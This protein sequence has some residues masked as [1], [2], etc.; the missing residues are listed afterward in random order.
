MLLAFSSASHTS[1]R[2]R[3]RAGHSRSRHRPERK[4]DQHLYNGY[5]GWPSQV[6]IADG[7]TTTYSYSNN[8]VVQPATTG[9]RWSRTTLDGFGRVTKVETGHDST[10]VSVAETNYA[11][12]ACSPLGKVWRVSRP[13]APGTNPVC[14]T[15]T[16][17]GSG[18]TLTVTTAA[19]EGT[20]T[21]TYRYQGNQT[22]VTDAAGKWKTFTNDAFGNVVSVAEP[23]PGTGGTQNPTNLAR[24]K[25]AS[26]GSTFPWSPSPTADKAVDG[27]TDGNFLDY[28]VTHTN[29]DVNAWWQVD[30]GAS[31]S[32]SSVVIWN[33]TDCCQDRLSDYWVFISDTP[34]S[35]SDTPATLQSRPGTWS[36]H[37]TSYPNPSTTIAAS[38]QGR[39]VRVQLS[40]TERL[41]MAEVQVM[42]AFG[43]SGG[44]TLTTN[45]I[46]NGA[47][48]LTKVS[49]PRGGYTQTRTFQWT[50]GTLTSATN[51]EN[52]TMSYTYDG[53]NKVLTRMDAK[54][55]QAKYIYDTYGRLT[56]I[57]HW[58][59][60]MYEYPDQRIDYSYDTNPYVSGFLHNGA[61]RLAAVQFFSGKF[62]YMYDYNQPGRTTTYRLR[63]NTTSGPADL[64][65]TYT[66][67]NEGRMTQ[68]RYPGGDATIQYQY[69]AMGRLGG[70]TGS[71]SAS[72]VYGP[73]GELSSL[74]WNSTTETRTHNGLGQ[75]T[76]IQTTGPNIAMDMQY[77]F[78][79]TQNNG[80]ITQSIDSVTASR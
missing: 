80:R 44:S 14:T 30:L 11:P 61:G 35:P 5:F 52:G 59:G 25:L 39:Y 68:Q 77:I 62:T 47:D 18:R 32:I 71:L 28:S 26:Q 16:Y 15:Y 75:L 69:D 6:T 63:V 66:W 64:D 27:N 49:M 21:T 73:A 70:T 24:G 34:F 57:Q 67:D 4:R 3:S 33:R 17:D 2:H 9:S 51:P 31:A 36:S 50:G 46:Y 48:Q 37:Q 60:N 74:T 22:T 29:Y 12:C 55:Q 54:N 76:R 42:G 79:A 20:T 8:P 56:Q 41:H 65:A 23:D 1:G 10:T 19:P 78:S 38:A 13:Y 7:A 40:G 45:Y 53:S 72:A 43:G 58:L